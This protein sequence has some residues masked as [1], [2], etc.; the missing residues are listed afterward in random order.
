[1]SKE[2]LLQVF[3]WLEENANKDNLLYF[4]LLGNNEIGGYFKHNN[5]HFA[6]FYINVINLRI[7]E[8]KHAN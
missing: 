3:D 1:M 6:D 2:E 7:K 4:K 5:K 8:D